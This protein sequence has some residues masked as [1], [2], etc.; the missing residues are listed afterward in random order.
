MSH[1]LPQPAKLVVL[2]EQAAQGDPATMKQGASLG[3]RGGQR[4]SRQT[5][6]AAEAALLALEKHAAVATLQVISSVISMAQ[7]A[8]Q[9][10]PR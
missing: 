1:L 4:S 9:C 8:R 5:L 6:R 7:S 3:R 10:A 2:F